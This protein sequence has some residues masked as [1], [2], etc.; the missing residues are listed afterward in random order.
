MTNPS[1]TL[2]VL[3]GLV[4]LVI[5]WLLTALLMRWSHR[6]G[7]VDLPSAR[8]VHSQPTPRGGGL[9]IY[10]GAAAGSCCLGN[11]GVGDALPL[12]AISLAIVLLGLVDDWRPLPWQ[13][14]L[15]VQLAIAAAV[16]SFSFANLGWLRGGAAVLW[17]VALTNAFN[18]LDNMDALSAG[19]ATIAAIF[20]G[21]A[22][23]QAGK[24]KDWDWGISLSYL[25]FVG[26]CLGFLWFNRPPAR[27]FMGDAGSTFLGFFLG[28]R[29]LAFATGPAAPA[30]ARAALLFILAVPLYDMASVI[31]LRLWQGRSPFHADK[32][33][34]SH[35][36]T[37]LGLSRPASVGII[38]LLALAS[39][40]AGLLLLS[41]T[42]A[43]L[44]LLVALQ[45]STWWLAIAGMEYLR[46][47]QSISESD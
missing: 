39:G 33:H 40:L 22:V 24:A 27:I 12:L 7:L 1:W 18:M 17:I 26:A 28:V 6:L 9:A 30:H 42:N 45:F 19:V 2:P 23:C 13:L 25:P 46:H 5:S 34:L 29:S 37:Q 31:A 14:R 15:G 47:F 16:V 38:L 3:A 44:A 8:K 35:R 20:L 32:Q 11:S 4:A 21:L 10:V 41:L 43:Y 36:L